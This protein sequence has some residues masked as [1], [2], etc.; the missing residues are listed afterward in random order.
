M[1][2]LSRRFT[3]RK[4]RFSWPGRILQKVL[5]V[6]S[7]TEGIARPMEKHDARTFILGGGI[8]D[9]REPHVHARGHRVLFCRA[10]QLDAKDASRAFGDDL[11]HRCCCRCQ[12]PCSLFANRGLLSSTKNRPMSPP[13]R[14]P[15]RGISRSQA[16]FMMTNSSAVG[17]ASKPLATCSVVTATS[18]GVMPCGRF[19]ANAAWLRLA[20]LT[21]NLMNA[22]KRLAL[23]PEL[24]PARPKR[25]RFL[26]FNTRR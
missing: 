2:R 17:A 22:L 25:L 13:A 18:A 3:P 26:I 7:G 19:G 12:C 10:I 14:A 9:L 20:V 4:R 5:D 8:Q 1:K 23:P 15:E 16:A 6:V 21:H 24:M 11:I